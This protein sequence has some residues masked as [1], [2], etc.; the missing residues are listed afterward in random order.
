MKIF[1]V[2][3]IGKHSGAHFYNE[4]FRQTLEIKFQEVTV[5]SNYSDPEVNQHPVLKNFYEGHAIRKA[6]LL[7]VSLVRFY[8]FTLRNRKNCFIFFSY[9]NA[10]EILFAFPLL[11]C[12]ARLVDAHEVVS[13]INKNRIHNLIRRFTARFIYQQIAQAV[14]IHSFR[15]S[16]IL[17]SLKVRGQRLYVPHY[18]YQT[19]V[20]TSGEVDSEVQGLI[21]EE[22][23]NLLFFGFIRLSKGIDILVETA[24]MISQKNL[25][26]KFNFIIAGNDPDKIVNRLLSE[27]SINKKGILSVLTRYITDNEMRF[28]FRKS[29]FIMLPYKD[30][31]QSGV[32]EMAVLFR[33]PVITSPIDYFRDY[34]DK[35]Q[36]FGYY[37]EQN[38]AEKYTLLLENLVSELEKIPAVYYSEADLRVFEEFKNPSRFLSELGQLIR[39]DKHTTEN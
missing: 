1:L 25:N 4:R 20:E 9:G 22:K 13:L 30:I 24:E 5:I 36:S 17:D 8:T 32:L 10:Y 7:M 21:S 11:F 27:K 34:L 31:S 26:A 37:A 2:D 39:F 3:I 14:I 28:L 35:F 38:Y 18:S 15:S 16:A 12:S 33:K 29:D 6:W 19:S 23:I